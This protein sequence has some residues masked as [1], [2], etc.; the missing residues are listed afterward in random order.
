M[1]AP[2]RY[3]LATATTDTQP[4]SFASLALAL[5][6]VRQ[7]A[8]EW[9]ENLIMMEALL[10]KE[11]GF[12]MYNI[13][14]HPHKYILYY[15]RVLEGSN[16]KSLKALSQRAWNYLNDRYHHPQQQHSPLWKRRH[17]HECVM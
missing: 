3:Y 8:V 15:I 13:M 4:H 7:L 1:V 16:S 11:L 17:R 5:S 9:R 2:V 6:L 14:D 10:L 12:S